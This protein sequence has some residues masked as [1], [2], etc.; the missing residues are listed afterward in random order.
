MTVATFVSPRAVA[1]SLVIASGLMT[2]STASLAQSE[3]TISPKETVWLFKLAN[4]ERKRCSRYKVAGQKAGAREYKMRF[5]TCTDFVLAGGTFDRFFPDPDPNM[6]ADEKCYDAGYRYGYVMENVRQWTPCSEELSKTIATANADAVANC[7]KAAV[8]Q[9]LSLKSL[10]N[11]I[12]EL[13]D[14]GISLS[15]AQEFARIVFFSE[16]G[17]GAQAWDDLLALTADVQQDVVSCQLILATDIFGDG[18]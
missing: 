17:F 16:V 10:E 6:D 4:A 14:H 13:S 3:S 11:E 1:L 15:E 18:K 9:K 5:K 7:R 8:D 12:Y 2:G